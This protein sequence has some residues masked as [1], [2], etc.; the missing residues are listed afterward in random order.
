MCLCVRVF[1]GTCECVCVCVFQM[2]RELCLLV[3]LC[4]SSY[5]YSD[6]SDRLQ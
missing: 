2:G 4:L 1:V 6:I 3:Q 5:T